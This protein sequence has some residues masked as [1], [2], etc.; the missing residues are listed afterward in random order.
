MCTRFRRSIGN[1]TG[2]MTDI[3]VPKYFPENH[4]SGGISLK[5]CSQ[6]LLMKFYCYISLS[7]CTADMSSL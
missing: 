3:E 5:F 1:H 2:E 6:L 4:P 7:L